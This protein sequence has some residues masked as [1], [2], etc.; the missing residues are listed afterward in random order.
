MSTSGNVNPF[1]WLPTELIYCIFDYL[2]LDSLKAFGL[3]CHRMESIFSNYSRSRFMLLIGD[4]LNLLPVSRSRPPYFMAA[5]AR[6]IK[7]SKRY[8][9]NLYLSVYMTRI[10]GDVASMNCVLNKVL[11]PEWLQQLVVLKLAMGNGSDWYARQLTAAVTKMDRLQELQFIQSHFVT[12]MSL[13]EVLNIESNTVQRMVLETLVPRAINCPKLRKLDVAAHLDAQVHFGKQYAQYGDTEPF[14]KLKQLE[15]FTI[16]KP[17]VPCSYTQHRPGYEFIFYKHL[18]QL[19][20]LHI[21]ETAV[22]E[23]ILQ[24]ICESC[25]QLEDLFIYT[26]QAIDS[27]SLRYLSN[28]QHLRRLAIW[29]TMTPQPVS[30]ASVKLPKLEQLTLGNLEVVWKSLNKFQSIKSLNITP[31]TD[32]ELYNAIATARRMIKLQFLWLDFRCIGNPI[33]TLPVLKELSQLK[34]L[35]LENLD[36]RLINPTYMLPLPQLT[37]LVLPKCP[38][39]QDLLLD[40]RLFPNVKKIE[41]KVP[42][43]FSCDFKRRYYK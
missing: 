26:L 21:Y 14:W 28:L 5:A 22:S 10:D 31:T 41:L 24:C 16:I 19:K 20:K 30:F 8:F 7:H 25:V 36:V 40:A 17:I 42:E 32:D 12:E 27:D 9:Q 2:D 35:I 33:S 3:T 4:D 34:T 18:T 15:E 39:N 11:E 1:Q 43:C 37:R 6:M 23:K 38:G 29:F 13:S